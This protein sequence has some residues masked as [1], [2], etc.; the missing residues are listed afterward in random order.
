MVLSPVHE[1]K[2]PFEVPSIDIDCFT[3][4]KIIGDVKC[5]TPPLVVMVYIGSF[6]LLESI[7]DLHSEAWGP[8]RRT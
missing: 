4:Y 7:A 1:G 3:Y 8:R 6:L 2:A 5:G